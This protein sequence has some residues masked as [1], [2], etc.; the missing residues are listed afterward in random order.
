[1]SSAHS[2]SVGSGGFETLL[3]NERRPGELRIARYHGVLAIRW[4]REDKV[5]MQVMVG[6]DGF[7]CEARGDSMKEARNRAYDLAEQKL[8][9]VFPKR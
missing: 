2:K 3:A 4:R 6:P 9:L 8:D 1:M 7:V 5:W